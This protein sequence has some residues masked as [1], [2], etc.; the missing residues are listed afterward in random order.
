MTVHGAKGLQAPVVILPD[1]CTLP[2][3]ESP[4]FWTDDT[5]EALLLWPARKEADDALSRD[6]RER[7]RE[8]RDR[9]YRRLLYVAMTRTWLRACSRSR[10]TS[11]SS[12]S[13]QRKN[14]SSEG[15]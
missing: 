9:E 3:E 1:T 13:I 7:T 12:T 5:D 15:A 4:F 14:P 2:L 8:A 11:A 6:A 10:L